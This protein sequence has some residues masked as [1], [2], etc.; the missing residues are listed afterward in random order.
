MRQLSVK[1]H[2]QWIRQ[3]RHKETSQLHHVGDD[4]I[5]RHNPMTS[6]QSLVRPDTHLEDGDVSRQQMYPR[7]TSYSAR[8]HRD[9]RP[10]AYDN[11]GGDVKNDVMWPTRRVSND[12]TVTASDLSQVTINICS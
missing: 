1:L 6:E 2:S 7:T 12:V 11:G 5:R 3:D 8:R 4:V 9:V 10:A